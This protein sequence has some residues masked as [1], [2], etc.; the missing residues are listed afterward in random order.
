MEPMLMKQALARALLTIDF[1]GTH[2]AAA[3]ALSTMLYV[4]G[5]H[6]VTAK[7]RIIKLMERMLPQQG[8]F[9]Q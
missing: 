7:A 3:R 9:Q 4:N 2:A 6:A 8:L 1:H 5:I